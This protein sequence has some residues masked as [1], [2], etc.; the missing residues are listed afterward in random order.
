[1]NFGVP[2]I[3]SVVSHLVR[4]VLSETESGRIN[5]D[6]DKEE[7]DPSEEV[8][9][10]L[11]VYGL[12]PDSLTDRDFCDVGLA[13]TLDVLWK[14]TEFDVLNFVEAYVI[15]LQRVDV[16]LDLSHGELSDSEQTGAWRDLVPK[17]TTD[18]GGSKGD[19]AVIEGEE[20]V[21]V[22]EMALSGLWSEVAVNAKFRTISP[23]VQ[24]DGYPPF[25]L[26]SRP[27]IAVEH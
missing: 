14:E 16:V 18:L 1:M 6:A 24:Q 27:N 5:T 20:T 22:E 10:G 21:E 26:S 7:G 8:T 12:V 15:L 3:R 11:V 13:S 19:L 17:R 23:F 2:T 9:Q 4:H 25:D